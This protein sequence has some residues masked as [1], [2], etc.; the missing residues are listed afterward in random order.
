MRLTIRS[1]LVAE[2]YCAEASTIL[3]LLH[4]AVRD[5]ADLRGAVLS[6][7]DLSGAV[8]RGADLSGAVLR[9]AVL[10]DSTAVETGETLK[11]YVTEVVPALVA[12]GGVPAA[13]SAPSPTPGGGLSC[14]SSSDAFSALPL[15]DGPVGSGGG[16][17]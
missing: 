13:A 7:A 8:L 1:R 10:S 11:Q 12:A 17:A 9:G 2:L 4:L 5:S 15:S 14:G 16:P 6:G 3:E